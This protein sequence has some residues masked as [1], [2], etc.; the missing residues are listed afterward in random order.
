MGSG[1]EALPDANTNA[2]YTNAY[3]E[4]MLTTR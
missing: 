1:R 2:V 3:G 4:R